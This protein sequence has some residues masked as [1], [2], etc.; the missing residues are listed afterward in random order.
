MFSCPAGGGGSG[1]G[2]NNNTGN[3][4]DVENTDPG[5]TLPAEI[6][7][8]KGIVLRLIHAGNFIIGRAPLVSQIEIAV[9]HS[10]R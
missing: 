8:A 3:T 5:K 7:S 4:G 10:I 2:G 6:T 1:S 9:K